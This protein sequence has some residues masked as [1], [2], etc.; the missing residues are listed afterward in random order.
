[1]ELAEDSRSQC[2]EVAVSWDEIVRDPVP[3]HAEIIKKL[4][5]W[6]L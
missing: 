5:I 3:L 2:P 1:M 4:L 6:N